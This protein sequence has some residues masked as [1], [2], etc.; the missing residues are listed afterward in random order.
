LP[1]F[2]AVNRDTVLRNFFSEVFVGYKWRWR[3]I[4]GWLYCSGIGTVPP[5]QPNVARYKKHAQNFDFIQLSNTKTAHTTLFLARKLLKMAERI[6]ISALGIDHFSFFLFLLFNVYRFTY[7]S[8][9][10]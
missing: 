9:L 7:P 10:T 1:Q 6:W 2:V 5:L 8:Q 4:G 3:Y